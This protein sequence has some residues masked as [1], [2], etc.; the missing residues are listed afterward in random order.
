QKSFPAC[1]WSW[2]RESLIEFMRCLMSCDGTVYSMGGYPRIEFAVASEALAQDVHHAFVRLGIVSKL[3]RKTERC[4][5]VEITE[6]ESVERYQRE[7]GWI[8][9]KAKRF[10][11]QDAV[12]RSNV[13]HIPREVWESVRE[14]CKR[15]GISM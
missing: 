4:W 5:R 9:E 8:G 13:G 10:G 14:G 1:V 6:P 7:I 15:I 2:T 11:A 12:R 3:W